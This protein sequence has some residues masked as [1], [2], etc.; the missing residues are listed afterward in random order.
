MHWTNMDSVKI[1]SWLKVG[2]EKAA[3]GNS[4]VLIMGTE[5]DQGGRGFLRVGETIVDM[6]NSSSHFTRFFD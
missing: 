1:L 6:A 2:Y 3:G 4:P 5:Q